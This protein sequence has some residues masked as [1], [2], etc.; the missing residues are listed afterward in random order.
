MHVTDWIPTLLSMAGSPNLP[1]KMDGINQWKSLINPEEPSA[2]TE[3]VYDMSYDDTRHVNG[4]AIRYQQWKLIM[5]DPG[6]P[7]GWIHETTVLNHNAFGLNIQPEYHDMSD[8]ALI[9]LYNLDQ[10]P[11]E[12]VNVAQEYPYMVKWLGQKIERYKKTMIAPNLGN[13]LEAGNP[14]R[15]GGFW[16][17]N[18]CEAKSL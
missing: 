12:K 10:D 2:R 6:S 7:N 13:V 5:G 18:W 15:N 3:M 8:N 11:L 16:G 1:T 4:S 17:T 14:N 9:R